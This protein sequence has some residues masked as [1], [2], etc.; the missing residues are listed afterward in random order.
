[1]RN[2]F[3]FKGLESHILLEEKETPNPPDQ[4][5]FSAN[6]DCN[7][8]LTELGLIVYGQKWAVVLCCW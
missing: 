6:L 4:V 1:M 7:Y 3:L 2:S 8:N 5:M